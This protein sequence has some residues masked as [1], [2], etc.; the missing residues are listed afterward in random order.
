MNT[1]TIYDKYIRILATGVAGILFIAGNACSGG[2]AIEQ[3]EHSDEPSIKT[4]PQEIPPEYILTENPTEAQSDEVSDSTPPIDSHI[5]TIDSSSAQE[6]SSVNGIIEKQQAEI[7]TLY[8]RLHIELNAQRRSELIVELFTDN[9]FVFRSLGFELANRDLSSSNKLDSI[10]GQAALGMLTDSHPLTRTNAALLILRIVPPDAMIAFTE[11][12][13][14]EDDPTAADP[15][16]RGISRWPN[17]EVANDVIRWFTRTE[18][19]LASASNATWALEQDGFLTPEHQQVVLNHLRTIDRAKL[20]ESSMKLFALLG[21]ASD[22]ELLVSV[23]LADNVAQQKWAASALVETPRAVELIVQAAES[24]PKLFQAA[25]DALTRH[26]HTPEGL[27]R[28]V[29]LP[30]PDETTRLAAIQRMGAALDN[31]RLAEAI[32]LAGLNDSLAAMLLNRLLNGNVEVTPRV[33]KGILRYAEIE[34]DGARPN[35]A[36]EAAISLDNNT[37]DP[38]DRRRADA[39]KGV[40]LILLGRFDDAF[41]VSSP[42]EIWFAALEYKPETELLVKIAR[43][44]ILKYQD[45]LEPEQKIALEKIIGRQEEVSVPTANTVDP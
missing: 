11:S 8:R 22:L 9:R 24:N 25:S 20:S 14:I 41:L 12:L 2:V 7:L 16:L 26:R 29:S 30:Y 13:A 23:L 17:R 31:D 37:I 5:D 43:Q 33:A 32:R 34:L 42:I 39:M 4:E 6:Q 27:R 40:S 45:V 3:H 10:V 15:M 28:L 18:V 36:L 19:P 44:M 1:N 21:N 38:S 35:R